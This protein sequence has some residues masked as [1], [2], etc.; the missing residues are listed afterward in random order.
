MASF[1]Q[2][3]ND[4]YTGARSIDF[5]GRRRTWYLV[6]LALILITLLGTLARG[7]F[8]F[9]IEFTGGSQ[10]TVSSPSSLDQ[11]TATDAV[12]SVAP[13][14]VPRVSIVG[15]DSIRV[16]TGQ[17][18]T[19]ESTAVRNALSDAYAV[20]T[21]QVASSFIGAAWGNDV[22]QQALR[23][24]VIFVVLAA[25]AMWA[26]FR[27]WKMSLAAIVALLHDL[28]IV[29]GVYGIT[30]TEVSPAAVIGLLTILGYSLY[31][32]VVVFDKIRENT[33]EALSSTTRTFSE[34][35]NLAENQTLVRSI[36]TSIV[37]ALPVAAILVIGAFVLGA[38]TLR[39]ISLALLIG[40]IVGT[41]STIF[42]A[43]PLYA[44]LRSH[45]GEIAKHDKRVESTR[46]KATAPAAPAVQ[47]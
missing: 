29:A 4:L 33:A 8:N 9:G 2:F 25:L 36:N 17:L 12:T 13:E 43:A 24:L 10:F 5:V 19:D 26:Y 40:I 34:T 39:D 32:T 45:E 30:G 18:S 47:G 41:Y 46:A 27:T 28:V 42:V 14:T 7:G 1:S 44:Q 15:D 38:G 23:G 20:P 6:S 16:Q 22:T 11:A 31:D 35:V 3:G 37:A 21:E